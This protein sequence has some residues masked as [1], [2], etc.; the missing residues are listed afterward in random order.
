MKWYQKSH[1]RCL[2]DMHLPS[3]EESFRAYSPRRYAERMELARVDTAYVYASNCLGLCLYPT[4][5]GIRHS[6]VEKMDLF[7]ETVSEIRKKGIGVVGYLNNWCTEVAKRHPDW[8]V[9]GP[10]GKTQLDISRYGV[11]C[12]NSP[13]QDYFLS[14]I[15]EMVSRYEID[16]LWI[17]MIGFYMPVCTCPY[18]REKFRA[19]TGYEIPQTM[20][21]TDKAYVSYLAFKC[22]TVSDYVKRMRETAQRA[23]PGLPVILQTAP[24]SNSFFTGVSDDYFEQS[25]FCSG[26]FYA[27]K[28]DTDLICRVLPGLSKNAPFEYMTSRAPNLVYHTGMN[29][30]HD[31][32]RQAMASILAGGSFLF[33]D[34]I[35][36]D[37]S[38]DETVYRTMAKIKAL[39]EP[40]Y[41]Y[42]DHESKV[43]REV[44]VY[45][46][47]DSFM[48]EEEQGA[49]VSAMYYSRPDRMYNRLKRITANLLSA[50]V[51]HAVLTERSIDSLSDYRCVILPDLGRLKV[52]EAEK[53]R[54]YV[55]AG[56][57]L[58]ASG[59]SSLL[60]TDG[61][62]NDTFLLA[63]V[64]GVDYA[65]D[66]ETMPVYLRPSGARDALFFPH[67]AKYPHMYEKNPPRITA[68]GGTEILAKLTHPLT[69][70]GDLRVFSSAISNPPHTDTEFPC[71]T[72]HGFGKG[73]V[74]YSAAPLEREEVADN[75]ALFLRLI[76]SLTGEPEVTVDAPECVEFVFRKREQTGR[77][78][79]SLLN[80]QVYERPV[81]ICPLNIK[82]KTARRPAR[83][84]AVRGTAEHR[85]AD[86]TLH[87]TLDRLELFDMIVL[88]Y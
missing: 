56:G 41:P 4:D 66:T 88:E 52:S 81:P 25:E 46:N 38:M 78:T 60:Q 26:D 82:I 48:T 35:D 47:F 50:G 55:A 36:P 72:E 9:V 74:I 7:G 6:I 44:A 62:R 42:I 33:I 79:L 13:Y 68:R 21:Y 64:F 45:I 61:T 57:T 51:D 24:W 53:L 80:Y 32:A 85:Y 75:R 70:A 10:D 58:Y 34:A 49:P 1:F 16:G 12:P 23:R 69:G 31:M 11:C 67:T 37:G 63:D 2:V 15:G 86:G 17:D 65:G 73:R 29:S 54:A 83:A 30:F 20:D 19:R 22:Q 39:M 27:S 77:H 87:L 5:I 43:C 28:E 59:K 3:R 71:I 84:Y 40:F 76:R 14:L 8:Q 18:C